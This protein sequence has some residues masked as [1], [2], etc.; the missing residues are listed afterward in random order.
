MRTTLTL[1]AEAES[2]VKRAM[3]ESGASFKQVVNGAI[4]R[5]LTFDQPRRFETPAV[6]MGHPAIPLDK[7]LAVAGDLEDAELLRKMAVGK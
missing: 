7:A 3:A 2:L 5:G 1:D 6:D 4:V